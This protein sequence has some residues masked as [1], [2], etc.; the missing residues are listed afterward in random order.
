MTVSFRPL[1]LADHAACAELWNAT[2]GLGPPPTPAQLGDFLG[3]NPGF[4]QV[5]VVDDRIFGV[6]LASFD[7]IRG[8][9]YRAAVDRAWRQQGIGA[10]LATIAAEGLRAAGAVRINLHVF[11]S[12]TAAIAFWRARGWAIHDGLLCMHRDLA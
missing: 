7:G 11:A 10:S 6:L 5:A 4:S 3:R 2:E 1:D 12:N 9:F 8:Y